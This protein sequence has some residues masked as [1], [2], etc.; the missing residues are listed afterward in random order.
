MTDFRTTR[1]R[2]LTHP[3]LAGAAA[4]PPGI[5]ETQVPGLKL[6]ARGKVRDMYELGDLIT[7]A[8]GVDGNHGSNDGPTS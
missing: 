8:K 7:V 4:P 6:F 5:S 2:A 3:F 1:D